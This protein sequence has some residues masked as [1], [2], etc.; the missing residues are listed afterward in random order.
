MRI[1][2]ERSTL[3]SLK[4][5]LEHEKIEKRQALEHQRR[6]FIVANNLKHEP[7]SHKTKSIE[8]SEKISKINFFPFVYGENLEEHRRTVVAT[9]LREEM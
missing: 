9:Q 5:Q 3:Y 1:L 6:A 4:N 7:S 2:E 8:Y